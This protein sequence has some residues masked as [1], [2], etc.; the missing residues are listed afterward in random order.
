MLIS[1]K[2][3]EELRTRAAEKATTQY[4]TNS[5]NLEED[6]SLRSTIFHYSVA[7]QKGIVTVGQGF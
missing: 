4:D 5:R 2:W 7:D 3:E 6:D 1:I